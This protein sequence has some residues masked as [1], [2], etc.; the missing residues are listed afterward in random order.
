VQG[1]RA[2]VSENGSEAGLGRSDQQQMLYNLSRIFSGGSSSYADQAEIMY[3]NETDDSSS[4][5]EDDEGYMDTEEADS[6]VS[7]QYLSKLIK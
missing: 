4:N 7:S 1:I 2:A 6:E 5:E 3:S